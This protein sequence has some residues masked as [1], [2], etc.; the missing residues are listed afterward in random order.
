[1]LKKL[2]R[3][4]FII[5]LFLQISSSL[6]V[7]ANHLMP[8]K[9]KET[10]ISDH[11]ESEFRVDGLFQSG[12]NLWLPF[13]TEESVIKTDDQQ[14]KLILKTK[15][16]EYLFSNGWVFL[17][18]VDNTVKSFDFLDLALQ[19]QILK[20]KIIPSFIIPEG[21]T[22]PRD[23]AITTGHLPINLRNVELATD[24]EAR[25]IKLL[26]EENSKSNLRL[27]VYDYKKNHLSLLKIKGEDIE[28]NDLDEINEK[29]SF[30]SQ[31]K[32]YNDEIYFSDFNT[33][34][35]YKLVEHKSRDD[36]T[37]ELEEL[38]NLEN[39]AGLKDFALSPD[40]RLI[41]LLANKLKTLKVFDAKSKELIKDIDAGSNPNQVYTFSRD[42]NETDYAFVTARASNELTIVNS[43]DHRVFKRL[44]VNSMPVSIV[45]SFDQIFVA[46]KDSELLYSIDWVTQEV[47]S[48]VP[49]DLVPYKLLLKNKTNELLILGKEKTTERPLLAVF[50]ID[51]YTMTKVIDLAPDL[52][53]SKDMTLSSS[54]NLLIV[55]SSGSDTCAV[56]DLDNLE[57]VRKI[58]LGFRSHKLLAI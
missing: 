49:L 50:N 30:I 21:F 35:L 28:V 13:V 42:L 37:F 56:I 32:K 5:I 55:G 24:R 25:Y 34:T 39:N 16:N 48:K 43:L 4:A 45:S 57:I 31:I 47:I 2:A 29:I 15:D 7:K 10:L 6:A 20:N 3:Y 11:K 36:S 8:E 22:L 46:H 19:A 18:I 9:I 54:G 17:P 58:D 41:Y 40:G 1:M 38:I 33:A 14:L 51:L 52:A 53:M 26:A 27:L 12:D 23:L 44:K